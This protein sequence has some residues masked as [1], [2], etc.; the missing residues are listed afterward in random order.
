[1]N[2]LRP[3]H[4]G[5]AG[6]PRPTSPA[7]DGLAS[8]SFVFTRAF[9]SSGYTMPAL[10][11]LFTSLEPDSHDVMDAF[12]D[13][14]SF[15]VKTL[16]EV[17]RENGYATGGYYNQSHPHLDRRSGFGRGFDH[18]GDLLPDWTGR[19]EVLD[20]VRANRDR[21]FL[22]FVNARNTHHPYRP[23][24]EYKRAF[25]VGARGRI[26]DDEEE[27]RRAL[28][29][30]LLDSLRDPKSPLFG[31]I[32]PVRMK[33][34]AA[35]FDGEYLPAKLERIQQ[36]LPEFDSRLGQ[37]MTD[38]Y[39]ERVD[40]AD[41]DSMR[42]ITSLYDACVLEAD[43]ELVR[44]LLATLDE[45]GLAGRSI[46]VL[47]S[48]HGAQ[49][50]EHGA[51]GP[52][53]DFFEEQIRIPLAI[54]IPGNAQRKDLDALVQAQ[55]LMPTLLDLCR[56][57]LPPQVQGKSL[58]P[59]MEGREEAP[60]RRELFGENRFLAFLRTPEEKLIVSRD[61]LTRSFS[62]KDRLFDLSRDPGEKA[63]LRKERPEEYQRLRDR[64]RDHLQALPHYREEPL[65][66]P[67]SVDE[68]TRKRIR[69]TGYW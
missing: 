57:S 15:K 44:P 62:P 4:L 49:I 66:Y 31:M 69:E 10:M 21:P 14:L 38:L 47:T 11:T 12:K 36:M 59:L 24:P 43:Q 8:T 19:D 41:P 46:V 2:G 9:S 18:V 22:L 64:L 23:R 26:L 67:D 56:L 3:D 42:Y 51:L 54:R 30:R 33:A 53:T 32:D 60:A 34:Y 68:N 28:Y 39:N 17:F 40:A 48:D 16:A 13:R 63:N 7:A 6:Y 35:L 65:T 52:G 25:P 5:F 45:L 20:W 1:M 55:D 29:F 58:V 61:D 27:Y 50:M 37:L